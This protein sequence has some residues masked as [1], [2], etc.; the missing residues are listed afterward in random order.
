MECPRNKW[1]SRKT[2]HTSA[3]ISQDC[4]LVP[5]QTAKNMGTVPMTVSHEHDDWKRVMFGS[6]VASSRLHRLFSHYRGAT[7]AYFVS[8]IRLTQMV[9]TTLD[10]QMVSMTDENQFDELLCLGK[11]FSAKSDNWR[12]V[13]GELYGIE[14]HGSKVMAVTLLFLTPPADDNPPL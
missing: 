10:A 13:H 9:S 2:E 14:D 7:A 6:T 4:K 11:V 12:T 1:C 3:S 5:F 8:A